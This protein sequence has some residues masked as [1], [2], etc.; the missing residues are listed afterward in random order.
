MQID[1]QARKIF[2]LQNIVASQDVLIRQM[3]EYNLYKLNQEDVR[4][5]VVAE[6]NLSIQALKKTLKHSRKLDMCDERFS[7]AINELC[8]QW[9]EHYIC[10]HYLNNNCRHS[11]D[12]CPRIH[13]L[14]GPQFLLREFS[15]IAFFR[16]VRASKFFNALLRDVSEFNWVCADR[17][18]TFFADFKVLLE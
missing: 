11:A 17:I 12:K 6:K 2:E 7:D 15:R 5:T 9:V 14:V 10:R 1:F 3:Q 18:R 8:Y 13:R 16:N 4:L